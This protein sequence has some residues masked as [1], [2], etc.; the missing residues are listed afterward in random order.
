M[1]ACA[2]VFP[3]LAFKSAAKT[4]LFDNVCANYFMRLMQIWFGS[5]PDDLTLQGATSEDRFYASI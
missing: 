5:V 1:C 4:S 3:V 2:C